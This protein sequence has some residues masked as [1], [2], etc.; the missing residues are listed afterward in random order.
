MLK[1]D[2]LWPDGPCFYYDTALFPPGTDS[3]ALG[4]FARP[5]HGDRVCDLGCGTGLLTTLL[6]A[7]DGS[8]TLDCVELNADAA[9]LAQRGFAENGWAERTRVR[10]GD[11][12]RVDVLP[13][14]GSMDHVICNPP[15]YPQGSGASAPEGARRTAREET[16]CTLADVCAA[17]GRVLRWGGRFSL[18]HRAAR[19]T[20][21]LCAMRASGMEPKRLRFL[22]KATDAAPTLVL[23]EGRRGGKSGLTVE[24][25]LIPGSG[26][27]NTV[28]F[29]TER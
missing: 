9:A 20:D 27:W 4:Y 1:K 5:A 29:R 26:E 25:P 28:Y 23:V 17:A 24:P 19:L 16:D 14:A 15:Y 13:A 22:A 6:L 21:V 3:F 8:L 10:I 2:C 18:V 12:R 11:L 7:R